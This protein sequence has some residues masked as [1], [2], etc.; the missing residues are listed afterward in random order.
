[1][2]PPLVLAYAGGIHASAAIPWL[3]DT[4][5]AE[6]VTV[7]LDVG[8]GDELGELRARALECGATRAH[9]I[10]CRDEFA[11][12]VLL[13]S[14]RRR[15][16]REGSDE[17]IVHLPRPLIARKLAEIARIEN[18]VTVAH[19]STDPLFDAAILAIDAGLRV[20]APAREWAMSPDDLIA[21]VR[22]RRLPVIPPVPGY[23]VD[24]NLWGRTVSWEG[25]A[26]TPPAQKSTAARRFSEPALVDI[27]FDDGVPTAVNGVPMSGAEL[28][29]CVSLI[30]SQ[31]GI[32]RVHVQPDGSRQVVSEMPA[33]VILRAAAET[34]GATLTADVCLRLADGQYTILGPHDR[35]SL[36]VNHA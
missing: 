28:I 7:T 2:K 5:G 27:H 8:Q 13:P 17:P 33:A 18:A 35:Q 14:L 30:G 20:V 12:E 6:I 32:G 25:A 19:G 10:D 9:V 31:H 4:H 1:M 3:I 34:A 36:L 11:R 23:R 24:Q 21:Y 22:T 15:S 26:Q 16:W 29:E